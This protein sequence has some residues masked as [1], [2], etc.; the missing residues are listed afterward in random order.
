MITASI[1]LL[2]CITGFLFLCI[3][4]L[5]NNVR[6]LENS[7]TKVTVI[8]DQGTIKEELIAIHNKNIVVVLGNRVDNS[9][10]VEFIVSDN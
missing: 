8:T 10:V 4:G 2:F 5:V 9:K 7:K 3:L 1:V 6:K